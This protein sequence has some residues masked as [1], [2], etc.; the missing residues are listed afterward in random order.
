MNRAII[1]LEYYTYTRTNS[2]VKIDTEDLLTVTSII[3][4]SQL[5]FPATELSQYTAKF[6]QDGWMDEFS[7]SFSFFALLFYLSDKLIHFPKASLL[8]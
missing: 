7:A 1:L 3:T 4:N 5:A 8:S 2:L 6:N